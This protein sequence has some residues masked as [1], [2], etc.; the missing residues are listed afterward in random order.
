LIGRNFQPVAI[1][2]RLT[3][4]AAVALNDSEIPNGCGARFRP[5]FQGLEIIWDGHPRV[6]LRFA[7][8]YYLSPRWG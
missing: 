8:G 7:L 3:G 6:V 2:Y 4:A 5:P 1:C